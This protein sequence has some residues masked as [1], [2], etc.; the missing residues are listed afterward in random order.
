[1]LKRG[2]DGNVTASV[3]SAIAVNIVLIL[4]TEVAKRYM[5]DFFTPMVISVAALFSDSKKQNIPHIA[6]AALSS[7]FIIFFML[8]ERTYI[9]PPLKNANVTLTG[10]DFITMTVTMKEESRKNYIIVCDDEYIDLRGKKEF[11]ITFPNDTFDAFSIIYP[12]KNELK[13]SAQI[14]N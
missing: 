13:I 3:L 9:I 12:N 1:M 4:F 6:A 7:C 14:I 2:A 5:F 8:L 11:S 10:Y